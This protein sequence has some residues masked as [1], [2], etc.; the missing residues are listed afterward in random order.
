MTQAP[1][2]G[3][4]TN[5]LP[6]EG[7]A[8]HADCSRA[9]PKWGFQTAS[10]IHPRTLFATHYHELTEL[11]KTLPR[12][13]N[14][15]VLV[16][17]EGNQV[18]FLHRMEPGPCDRSYGIHVAQMAGMPAPVIERARE[19]LRQLEKQPLHRRQDRSRPA[20][21]Q[22]GDGARHQLGLFDL[23]S[24]SPSGPE[25]QL[26]EELLNLDLTQLTPMQALLKLNEWKEQLHTRSGQPSQGT[27]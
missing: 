21:A 13:K 7:N 2:E 19:L 26:A 24:L 4:L 1:E 10:Q 8:G 17:E 5:N 3:I 14:H 9:T 23:P 11:E 20:A 27:P 12:L 18:V 6:T 16:R 25:I 22:A 15:N